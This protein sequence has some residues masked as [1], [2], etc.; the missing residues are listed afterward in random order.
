MALLGLTQE[1]AGLSPCVED[2]RHLMVGV[3][4]LG[5]TLSCRFRELFCGEPGVGRVTDASLQ[6]RQSLHH[7]VGWRG[8]DTSSRS[9]STAY[10]V[11]MG[12]SL[13]PEYWS[14]LG[15][16]LHTG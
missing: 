6:W 5:H 9:S 11:V 4:M 10:A 8:T 2:G 1:P 16:R 15:S 12:T 13:E 3:S 14:E 7:V